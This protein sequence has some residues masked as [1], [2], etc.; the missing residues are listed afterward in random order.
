MS[1]KTVVAAAVAGAIS[2]LVYDRLTTAT[3][4]QVLTVGAMSG[5][6][7]IVV[8]MYLKKAL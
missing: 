5:V 2:S 7:S 4:T 1:G 3:R 8:Q 6:T